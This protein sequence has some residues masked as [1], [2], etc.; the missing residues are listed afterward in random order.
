MRVPVSARMR[1]LGR[2]RQARQAGEWERRA[3]YALHRG[4]GAG[5]VGRERRVERS[6]R[7]GPDG[8]EI[9]EMPALVSGADAGVRHDPGCETHEV[10]GQ[11]EHRAIE[12]LRP[13]GTRAGSEA[14]AIVAAQGV[15]GVAPVVE[16]DLGA[17]PI[18]EAKADRTQPHAPGRALEIEVGRTEAATQRLKIGAEIL[19]RHVSL[20]IESAR[21]ADIEAGGRVSER[22]GGFHLGMRGNWQRYDGRG[23]ELRC[24][25]HHLN[26]PCMPS[27]FY[28]RGRTTFRVPPQLAASP[29]RLKVDRMATPS[30]RQN[31]L[32]GAGVMVTASAWLTTAVTVS[33]TFSLVIAAWRAGSVTSIV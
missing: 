16:L 22:R 27:Q 11:V 1:V 28:D 20:E 5:V 17:Q 33:P 2:Q 30:L 25:T 14:T 18:A 23:E 15:E 32:F 24:K 29:D 7:A 31:Q 9:G 13:A 3:E 6:G 4:R 21:T 26:P 19:D 8:G 12:L 10:V